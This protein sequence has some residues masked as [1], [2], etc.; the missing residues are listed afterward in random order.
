MKETKK[1]RK[2]KKSNTHRIFKFVWILNESNV[3]WF[4]KPLFGISFWKRHT[5]F[6]VVLRKANMK[7]ACVCVWARFEKC[8]KLI[9]VG[10]VRL[11]CIPETEL[12]CSYM[13]FSAFVSILCM[14]SLLFAHF[15]AGNKNRSTYSRTLFRTFSLVEFQVKIQHRMLSNKAVERFEFLCE[16]IFRNRKHG[17][18]DFKMAPKKENANWIFQFVHLRSN[19]KIKLEYFATGYIH[20]VAFQVAIINQNY[21]SLFELRF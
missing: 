6:Y 5:N 3:C 16:W 4:R 12:I 7:C 8:A 1:E 10:V 9:T 11:E 18:T 19:T 13:H 17:A 15:L 21:R 20:I 2:E 14:V